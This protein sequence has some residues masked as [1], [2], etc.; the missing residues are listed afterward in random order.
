MDQLRSILS[1]R[2]TIAIG[3]AVIAIGVMEGPFALDIP[4]VEV[5]DD[6][7]GWIMAGLGTI[8]LRQGISKNGLGR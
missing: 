1:G 7:L 2:K 8:T 6:W 3:V 5:G 4:G